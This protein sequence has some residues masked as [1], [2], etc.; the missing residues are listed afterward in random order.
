MGGM[1]VDRIAICDN[2]AAMKEQI[3]ECCEKFRVFDSLYIAN[4]F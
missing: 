2:N 3:K 4:I 1:N